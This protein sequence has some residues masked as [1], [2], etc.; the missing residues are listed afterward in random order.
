M[1]AIPQLSVFFFAHE[2]TE[3]GPDRYRFVLDIARLADELGFAAVWL[4]ERHFH[5]FGGLF[6]NPAVVAAAVAARTSRIAVRAGSV[7]APLHHATRIAEEWGVV[8]ALSNGRAGVSLASGWNRADFVSAPE[9]FERRREI[10]LE[11][12]D[13][14]RALWRR[15][16][17]EFPGTAT[18]PVRTYP[19]PV[20]STI[21]LWLTATSGP[22]TFRAAAQRGLN[23]LTAYLQLDR[24]ALAEHVAEYRAT[25]QGDR[26]HV[27]LM[28]HACVADSLADALRAVERPL[29]AYQGQFLDLHQRGHD[30]SVDGEPLTEEEKYELARYAA[31]KYATE[32]GLIGG[33]DEVTARLH[34][35]ASIGVDEIACLVDFG[36]APAVVEDTL[37][38]LAKVAQG[39]VSVS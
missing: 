15:E 10:L 14:L 31:R 2:D 33:P 3:S 39:A 35:L 38:R 17:V 34:D 11:S 1:T 13:T 26:P 24:A 7:V 12:V 37:R 23:V 28:A 32:R 8:D 21:P 29:I 16:A 25:F 20:G 19:A 22:A 27:T 18:G 30:A 6:P 9:N 4:P 36:L 5:P